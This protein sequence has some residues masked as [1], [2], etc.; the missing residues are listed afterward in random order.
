MR[1][2]CVDGNVRIYWILSGSLNW[3]FVNEQCCEFQLSYVL[4]LESS[5]YVVIVGEDIMVVC[6]L[7]Y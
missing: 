2:F 5:W 1:S 7:C 6:I 3:I 4:D